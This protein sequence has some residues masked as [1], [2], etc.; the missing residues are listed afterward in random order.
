M[1]TLI[2]ILT[3]LTLSVS[4]A[5]AAKTNWMGQKNMLAFVKANMSADNPNF[6]PTKIEC[7][8]WSGATKPGEMVI[9]FTYT[10]MPDPKPFHKYNW[11]RANASELE[12]RVS[13]LRRS[14][15]PDLKYR[16]VSKDTFK[17]M[18]GST[19]GCALA[20]R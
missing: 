5:H 8:E 7:K 13:K 14:D 9:R 18:D 20:Y 16:I 6:Y 12:E 10:P 17:A 11:V 15:R 2:C 19:Y 1:R 4:G 3:I